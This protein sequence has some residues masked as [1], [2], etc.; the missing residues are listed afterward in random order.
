[1]ATRAGVISYYIGCLGSFVRVA[2]S[3]AVRAKTPESHLGL[4]QLEAVRIVRRQAR[5]LADGAIHVGDLAAATADDVVMVV[6]DPGLEAG[7]AAGRL[8]PAS[9]AG[10]GERAQNVVH[11]LGGDRVE[12]RADATGDVVDLEV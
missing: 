10:S 3:L 11:R 2:A 4:V 1:M 12:P 5:A 7:G 6:A 9:Q 8:D